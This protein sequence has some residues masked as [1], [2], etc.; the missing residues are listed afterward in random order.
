MERMGD[1]SSGPERRKPSKRM[2]KLL[3]KILYSKEII[4]FDEYHCFVLS[5]NFFTF[6]LKV[7][8]ENSVGLVVCGAKGE[9]PKELTGIERDML[10]AAQVFESRGNSHKTYA[11]LKTKRPLTLA[12]PN[13]KSVLLNPKIDNSVPSSISIENQ[14]YCKKAF[15]FFEV[16]DYNAR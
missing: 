2:E 14:N 12:N 13:P 1:S 16:S 6:F 8:V 11:N 9:G 3:S 4:R 5:L 15:K 10:I 7:P